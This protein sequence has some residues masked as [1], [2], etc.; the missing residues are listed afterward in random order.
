[1]PLG[2]QVIGGWHQIQNPLSRS[3]T[4]Y[5]KNHIAAYRQPMRSKIRNYGNRFAYKFAHNDDENFFG[6]AAQF[7]IGIILWC[8]AGRPKMDMRDSIAEIWRVGDRLTA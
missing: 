1:M 5:S 6:Y 3:L 8:I 7:G 4:D 2:Q